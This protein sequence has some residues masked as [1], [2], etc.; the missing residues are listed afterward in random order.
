MPRNSSQLPDQTLVSR[1]QHLS[2]PE[3]P[4]CIPFAIHFLLQSR[5]LP[6]K[7]PNATVTLKQQKVLLAANLASTAQILCL[8]HYYPGSYP[9]PVA[10]LSGGVN[11]L[12]LNYAVSNETAGY[13]AGTV[14]FL[15][16]GCCWFKGQVGDIS[17]L[18]GKD[19]T[20]C[21]GT[22]PLRSCLACQRC[23]RLKCGSCE[24]ISL[25]SK[26]VTCQSLCLYCLLAPSIDA[27]C[28]AEL[29]SQVLLA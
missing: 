20:E 12:A 21:D 6:E 7:P 29:W 5:G 18:D 16:R 10:S 24:N 11:L 25:S 27:S 8:L 23:K 28:C 19:A 14:V 2:T 1:R 22:N 26:T 15:G 17:M 9:N 13:L 3:S 4:A